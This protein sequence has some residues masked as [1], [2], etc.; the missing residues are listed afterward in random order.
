MAGLVDLGDLLARMEPGL[1]EKEY[2]FAT[3][4][5]A[6]YGD[7]ASLAPVAV[8]QEKE[9][10]T[11]VIERSIAEHAQIQA[12]TLFRK[13]SLGVHSSL[14]AVG[15]TAAVAGALSQKG[16]SANIIAG[17]FHDHIFVP[18]EQAEAAIQVLKCYSAGLQQHPG[19][20]TEQ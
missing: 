17:Y 1:D 15:L 13:I 11:L 18:S 3:F 16:I 14:E 8:I 9:G 20:K 7:L 10:L 2:V 6:R 4:R 19:I 12:D 5:G